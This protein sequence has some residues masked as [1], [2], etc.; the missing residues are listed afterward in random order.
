MTDHFAELRADVEAEPYRVDITTVGKFEIPHINTVN[1]FDLNDA[2]DAAQTDLDVIINVLR[3][4]MP[5]EDF[6]RLREAGLN[7]P[8]LLALYQA[9]QVHC[10]MSEGESPASSA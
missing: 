7:R 5:G 8:T 2:I 1:V 6:T 4:V 3:V 9:W 10:G